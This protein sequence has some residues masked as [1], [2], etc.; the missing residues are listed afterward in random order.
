ML[1]IPQADGPKDGDHKVDCELAVMN[2][3][4]TTTVNAQATVIIPSKGGPVA[5]SKSEGGVYT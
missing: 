5:I 3:D 1:G 4:G 2:H